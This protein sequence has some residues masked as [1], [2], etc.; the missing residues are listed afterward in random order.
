MEHPADFGDSDPLPTTAS[1]SLWRRYRRALL[2]AIPIAATLGGVLGLLLALGGNPDFLAFG[3]IGALASMTAMGAVIAAGTGLAGLVG[4]VIAMLVW[5]RRLSRSSEFPIAIAALGAATAAAT[6]WLALGIGS[7]LSTPTGA[8]W[9]PLYAMFA[10]T[11]G[12][13]AAIIAGVLVH[14]DELSAR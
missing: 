7:A 4:G 14:R 10:A 12:L 2:Q 3:G 8:D 11:A 9:F 13:V 5:D 6:L 1:G